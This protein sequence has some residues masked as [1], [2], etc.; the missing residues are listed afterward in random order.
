VEKEIK[1]FCDYADSFDLTSPWILNKREH[2][3]NTVKAS[4]YIATDMKLDAENV[5]LAKIIGL[6]HDIGRFEQWTKYHTMVDLKSVNHG[7]LSCEILFDRGLIKSF[8]I[9]AKYYPVIKYA[10]LNHNAGKIDIKNAPKLENVDAVLHAQIIRDADKI[11]I[12]EQ[13]LKQGENRQLDGMEQKGITPLLLE[14]ANKGW[15]I[16][17][18][19]INTKADS[20]IVY[21]CYAYDV[22]TDTAKTVFLDKKYPL[23]TYKA[24]KKVLTRPDAKVVKK[25]AKAAMKHLTR[26]LSF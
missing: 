6:L 19:N 4:G 22:Y 12:M 11:D 5:Y 16:D 24:Y 8:G 23:L 21:I 9:D 25:I 26:C 15:P 2:S 3:L 17:Y 20:V 13:I 7:R 14:E 1:T 18:A 10:V